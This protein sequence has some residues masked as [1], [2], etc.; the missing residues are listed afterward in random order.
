MGRI[1]SPRQDNFLMLVTALRQFVVATPSIGKNFGALLDNLTDERDKAIAGH[2]GNSAHSNPSEPLGRI[3]F[4]RNNHHFFAFAATSSL[5]AN[6]APANVGLVNFNTS[7]EL[8]SIRTHHGAPQFVQPCPCSLITPQPKNA[9]QPQSTCTVFLTGHKPDG[10]EPRC[11]WHPC[12]FKNGSCRYRNLAPALLAMKIA[13]SGFPRLGFAAAL[14]A[15]KSIR[16]TATGKISSACRFIGE[17]FKKLLVCTGVVLSRYR[18]WTVVH[19]DRYYMWGLLASSGYP[20][21]LIYGWPVHGWPVH[22]C[23][24]MKTG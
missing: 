4:N 24:S 13:T 17:P 23:K 20:A 2:I 7:A 22:G 11:Q 8:I 1:S 21:I 5:A 6:V 16:P 15:F 14:S 12:T 19:A 3:N 18:A 9:F 10:S